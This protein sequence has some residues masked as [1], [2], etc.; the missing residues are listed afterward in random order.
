MN[1]KQIMRQPLNQAPTNESSSYK[2]IWEKRLNIMNV[3]LPYYSV[4]EL[5]V[6]LLRSSFAEV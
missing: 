1:Y 4:D 6:C 2:Y 3:D 5:S